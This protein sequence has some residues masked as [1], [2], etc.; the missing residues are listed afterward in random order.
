[1]KLRIIIPFILFILSICIVAYRR[2]ENVRDVNASAIY[3]WLS[4][5][6]IIFLLFQ[7]YLSYHRE[8][9]LLVLKTPA[10]YNIIVIIFV[11]YFGQRYVTI[12]KIGTNI[13]YNIPLLLM[14]VILVGS[15]F[16]N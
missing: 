5:L 9:Y 11:G 15:I 4:L 10:I 6:L 7:I 13:W 3:V 1:M 16:L 14:F 8:G 12:G 2:I